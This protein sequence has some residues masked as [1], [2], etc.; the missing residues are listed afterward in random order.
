MA[1]QNAQSPRALEI[2]SEDQYSHADMV[3][4]TI[5]DSISMESHFLLAFMGSVYMRYNFTHAEKKVKYVK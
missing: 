5:C 1:G 2:L 4:Q 3:V